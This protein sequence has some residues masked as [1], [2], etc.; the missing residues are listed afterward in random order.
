VKY[1]QK[2][3]SLIEAEEKRRRTAVGELES[4]MKGRVASLTADHDRAL[5]GAEEYFSTAQNKLQE[6]LKE[7]KVG[8]R[9]RSKYP[10]DRL[11]ISSRSIYR[12]R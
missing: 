9:L 12:Y 11:L 3:Q 2:M 6:Q 8:D 10:L 5:R 4:Q 1:H 7:L